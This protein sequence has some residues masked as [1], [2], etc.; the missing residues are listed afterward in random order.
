MLDAKAAQT[1]L[2]QAGYTIVKPL[3]AAPDTI[4]KELAI[5][6]GVDSTNRTRVVE[7]FNTLNMVGFVNT[8]HVADPDGNIVEVNQ[9]TLGLGS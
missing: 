9:Q 7:V 5:A 6:L 8:F 3:G 4:S 1:R 2:S